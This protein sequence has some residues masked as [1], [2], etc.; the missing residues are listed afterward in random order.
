[1]SAVARGANN[2]ARLIFRVILHSLWLLLV[3]TYIP[4]FI[5]FWNM[6]QSGNLGADQTP[7]FFIV[8]VGVLIGIIIYSPV[9]LGLAGAIGLAAGLASKFVSARGFD[10]IWQI[11]GGTVAGA[12]ISAVL[13]YL[14]RDML[15]AF[16][17]FPLAPMGTVT[18]LVALAL[19]L[20]RRNRDE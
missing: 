9:L 13:G 15:S 2:P 11:A 18:A 3:A 17:A 4:L 20:R 19:S 7:D 6:P 12:A 10:K 5:H 14:L 8:G 16:L 1:M